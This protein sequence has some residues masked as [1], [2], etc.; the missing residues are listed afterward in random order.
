MSFLSRFRP[1][2]WTPLSLARATARGLPNVPER[3][4]GVRYPFRLLRYWFMHEMLREAAA[5]QSSPLCIAEVGV[6]H[7][8]Q[9]AFATGAAVQASDR[10]WWHRWDAYDCAP[11]TA[12]LEALGY[13]GIVT[14]DLE[15]PEAPSLLPGGAYDAVIACHVLEHLHDPEA[16]AALLARMLKPGGVLIGGGPV[17]PH[18]ALSWREQRLRRTAQP[19]GHVSVL[20]PRRLH[21]M[22]AGAGFEPLWQSGAFLMR[23]RGFVLEDHGWWLRSNLAFGALF[24][25]WPGE[26][27][28][29]WR[30]PGAGAAIGARQDCGSSTGAGAAQPAPVLAR[31]AREAG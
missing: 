11:R 13:T 27:Y 21:R 17:S 16:G 29:A 28:F 23:K 22:A 5:A 31:E 26:I 18:V 2:G 4:R 14:V 10:G 6:D 30:R 25:G 8:Q 19:H 3:V 7:G 15:S 1:L 24:P 20:S 12:E 9:L